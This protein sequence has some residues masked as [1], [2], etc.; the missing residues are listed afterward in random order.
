M[1]GFLT[2]AVEWFGKAKS[3][4]DIESRDVRKLSRAELRRVL[5]TITR[6]ERLRDELELHV[7]KIRR[8]LDDATERHT[9]TCRP[10]QDQLAECD[11]AGLRIVLRQKIDAANLVL[12]KEVRDINARLAAA[13]SEQQYLAMRCTHKAIYEGQLYRTGDPE[14]LA[15]VAMAESDERWAKARMKEAKRAL[16]IADSD[17][18]RD[19]SEHD[20]ATAERMRKVYLQEISRMEG[21]IATAKARIAALKAQVMES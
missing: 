10:I 12:E 5:A 18:A 6:R 19:V 17:L 8:E 15:Q 1:L 7:A 20:K 4:N 9:A 16:A 14:L 3:E 2:S 21:D 11:D 13:E